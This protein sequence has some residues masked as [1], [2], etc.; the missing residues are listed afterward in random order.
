MLF[1]FNG[2]VQGMK[3]FLWRDEMFGL[4]VCF[5]HMFGNHVFF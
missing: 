5:L 4:L 2:F 3:T 1:S